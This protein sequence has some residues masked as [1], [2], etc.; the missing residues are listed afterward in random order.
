LAF[1]F[2][3]REAGALEVVSMTGDVRAKLFVEFGIELGAMEEEREELAEVGK[4]G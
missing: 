1:G 4:H 2:V 3:A